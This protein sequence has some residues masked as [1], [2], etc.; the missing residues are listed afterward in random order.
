[1]KM[2][3]SYS[4][5]PSALALPSSALRSACKARHSFSS[6]MIFVRWSPKSLSRT[7]FWEKDILSTLF[8]TCQLRNKK[9]KH[10]QT[11]T[12]T[13]KQTTTT[14]KQ[15]QKLYIILF[16]HLKVIE[17]LLEIIDIFLAGLKTNNKQTRLLRHFLYLIKIC[18][19]ICKDK[20]IKNI[21]SKTNAL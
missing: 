2:K 10:K 3:K 7:V 15:Q 21:S 4:L 16:T 1:M 8:S 9:Q 17:K 11:N 12:Q 13:N 19:H 5:P 18:F 6:L 14:T 20:S